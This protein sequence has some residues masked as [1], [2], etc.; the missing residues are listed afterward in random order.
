MF[1]AH[2]FGRRYFAAQYFGVGVPPAPG[3]S[4][5]SNSYFGPRYFGKRYFGSRVTEGINPQ[6]A[7]V[8][9]SIAGFNVITAYFGEFVSEDATLNVQVNAVTCAIAGEAPVT[10]TIF[11]QPG[12]V[13]C[14]IDGAAFDTTF[15]DL[16]VTVAAVS[17]AIV[18]ACTQPPD[19]NDIDDVWTKTPIG[20][21]TWT[22][23]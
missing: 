2:Y 19:V 20:G 10:A 18:G 12:T 15:A 17:T 1:A 7:A 16:P 6:V 13:S 4:Y 9:C 3:G 11:A 5:W 23:Q 14:A 8:S 22:K 21:G